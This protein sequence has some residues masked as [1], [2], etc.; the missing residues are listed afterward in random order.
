MPFWPLCC[1]SKA[2]LSKNVMGE[3][4]SRLPRS[5]LDKPSSRQP[6]QATLSF[7]QSEIFTKAYSGAEISETG[8]APSCGLESKGPRHAVHSVSSAT[9][10]SV[11]WYVVVRCVRVVHLQVYISWGSRRRAQGPENCSDLPP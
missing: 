2:I 8:L 9:K 10:C 11:V 3:F 5:R 4:F 6:S 7:E 1:E